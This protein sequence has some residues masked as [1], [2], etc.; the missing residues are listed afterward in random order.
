[1]IHCDH[2]TIQQ[3]QPNRLQ[4]ISDFK[5]SAK[6]TQLFLYS[7]RK[8][9]YHHDRYSKRVSTAQVQYKCVCLCVYVTLKQLNYAKKYTRISH[10]QHSTTQTRHTNTNSYRTSPSVFFSASSSLSLS[11]S[12]SPPFTYRTVLHSYPLRLIRFNLI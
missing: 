7:I 5:S 1:M 6:V 8:L 3:H 11:L 4:V 9:S 2:I 10:Q 12:L